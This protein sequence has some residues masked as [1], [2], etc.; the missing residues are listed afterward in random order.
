MPI[1]GVQRR[2]PLAARRARAADRHGASTK[3]ASSVRPD[4]V[5][6]GQRRPV[7]RPRSTT[8]HTPSSG[9]EAGGG[10]A[11]RSPTTPSR[12]SGRRAARAAGSAVRAG[13]VAGEDVAG[14]A[15][16][17]DEVGDARGSGTSARRRRR[18][19]GSG[20]HGQAIVSPVRALRGRH[21]RDVHRRRRPTTAG[22][23]G[24]V[25]RPTTPAGR[26]VTGA[27]RAVDGART[28]WPTARPWPPTPCSSG[29]GRSSPWSPTAGFADVIEIARQ[30]RPSLYDQWADRPEPLVPRAAAPGG[31]RPPRRRRH[32]DRAASADA[33]PDVPDG[34]EAVA[35][36]LLHADLD[37]A[38]ER[39]WPSA[40]A[41]AGPRRD[42]LVRGVARVPGV[43]AHG[44]DRR[45]RLPAARGA[46]PTCA[47]STTWPT[48]CWS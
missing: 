14:G 40:L 9:G 37:P 13:R 28:C 18:V 24:A 12:S 32:R 42:V 17:L 25:A 47:A 16:V 45:Q 11:A 38:H 39:R 43:R 44:D 4:P 21:R 22:R 1:S 33:V 35:V 41:G 19:S 2:Q 30:D 5:R 6:A 34:V 48:R 46:G 20:V 10:H 23:Q 8:A 36:C 31:R 29:G 27:G 3:T 26:C 15:V 7:P